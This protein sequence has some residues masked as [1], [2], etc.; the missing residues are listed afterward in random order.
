[1]GRS[2]DR[3][4]VNRMGRRIRRRPIPLLLV[5]C[6]GLA[7]TLQELPKSG[8]VSAQTRA[9][10][11]MEATIPELQAALT[12]RS[13]T[14]RELVDQYLA[15]IAAYDKQGPTLNA[16]STIAPN[17]RTEAE[18]LDAERKTKGP[19][20]PLHGIPVIVKDN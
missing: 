1:M 8:V 9:F 5:V 4:R 12:T 2:Q 6:G 14:S 7:L 19:R 17:A 11:V 18:V 13:V 10:E 16:I 15:R 3:N 20:G